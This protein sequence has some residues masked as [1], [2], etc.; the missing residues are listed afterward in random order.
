MKDWHIDITCTPASEM[1]S[2]DTFELAEQLEGVHAAVALHE[3][4]QRLE[5]TITVQAQ[6]AAGAASAAIAALEGSEWTR[7]ASVAALEIRDDAERE[8]QRLEPKVPDLVGAVQIAEMAGVSRQRVHAIAKFPNFPP[9]LLETAAGAM[10]SRAAVEHFLANWD[11][12]RSRGPAA[13]Q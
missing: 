4:A 7:G 2:E 8:R 5:L 11:R 3:Q 13:K 1:G 10:R 6:D 12:S 9:V